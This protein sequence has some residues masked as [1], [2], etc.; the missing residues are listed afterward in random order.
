MLQE[1]ELQRPQEGELQR[2]QEGIPGFPASLC[3]HCHC[4]GC[5][6]TPL[7]DLDNIS[8]V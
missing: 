5:T 7:G 6:S 3:P 2:P 8:T 4:L 1:G